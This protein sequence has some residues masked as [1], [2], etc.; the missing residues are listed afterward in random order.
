[1]RPRPR[2]RRQPTA[3]CSLVL[4]FF[5][6]GGSLFVNQPIVGYAQCIVGELVWGG[7]VAVGVGIGD[8]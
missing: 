2:Q 8:R 7:S 5:G 3:R 4:T 6:F 1:M